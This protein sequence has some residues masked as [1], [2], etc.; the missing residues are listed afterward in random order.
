M[1]K[2]GRGRNWREGAKGCSIPSS[3][4]GIGFVI[5]AIRA[6]GAPL[7]QSLPSSTFASPP[8]RNC[9]P[10]SRIEDVA[11]AQS[12]LA[13]LNALFA[14]QNKGLPGVPFLLHLQRAP[15][16]DTDHAADRIQKDVARGICSAFHTW[17]DHISMND[18]KMECVYTLAYTFARVQYWTYI[19][20]CNRTAN[21]AGFLYYCDAVS[22]T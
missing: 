3:Q 19:T 14:R 17:T 7:F 18:R 12:L 8:C 16:L 22:I 5:G 21:L 13:R 20:M 9:K 10:F 15:P 4:V 6:I 2:R 1:R 11:A